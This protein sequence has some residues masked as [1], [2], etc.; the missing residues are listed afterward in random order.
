MQGKP[1]E[2]LPFLGRTGHEERQEVR[3]TSEGSGGLQTIFIP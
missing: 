2:D 1:C 3:K